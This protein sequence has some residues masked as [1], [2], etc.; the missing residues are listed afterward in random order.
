[1][2]LFTPTSEAEIAAA[3]AGGLLDETHTLEIKR[4]IAAG[5][6]AN[7][8]L[9]RDLA[10]FAI[11]GGTYIVGVDETTTPRSLAPVVLAGL[12]ERIEQVALTRIDSPLSVRTTIVRSD[13][14]PHLGYLVVAV[15]PSPMAP[16]MVDG[17]YWGRNDKTKY[18][19]SDAE[20]TRLIERRRRWE[21]S[22]TEVVAEA[23][24]ADPT[25]PE[26]RHQAHVFL[27]GQP[28]PRRGEMALEFFQVNHWQQHLLQEV[29]RWLNSGPVAPDGPRGFAPHLGQATQ[30]ERRPRGWAL[31]SYYLGLGR[32]VEPNADEGDLIELEIDEDGSLRAFCSRG[33]AYHPR[34]E[35]A[36]RRVFFERLAVGFTHQFVAVARGLS[37]AVGHHGS[38]DIG[39]GIVNMA[40]TVSW[41][42]TNAFRPSAAVYGADT[43]DSTTRATVVELEQRPE[44]VAE[45]L[46]GRLCRAFRVDQHPAIAPLL[47]PPDPV[48]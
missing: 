41:E 19:L 39:I 36:N 29:G 48:G 47:T 30:T 25:P 27:V 32:Q 37:E 14:D 13:A 11:D 46:V 20:V 10:S 4:E 12:P 6:G 24:A 16:H 8:E 3:A 21:H 17:R 28:V 34:G 38:W 1:M 42:A 35:L 22:T 5:S 15:S 9:A 31:S 44:A 43:Y 2:P 26:L 7:K 33:S 40:G 18:Q 23:I 45:R